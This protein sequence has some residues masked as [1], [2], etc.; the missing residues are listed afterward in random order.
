MENAAYKVLL[1]EDDKID[2]AAFKQLV[3]DESLP[4]DYTVTGSVSE[5]DRALSSDKFD[6]AIIDYLLGDGTAFDIFDRVKDIPV[7][8][9]TGCGDES[10]AVKAMKAGAYDYLIKDPE[11]N[12]LKVLPLTVENVVRYKKV[13]EQLGQYGRLK[14]ELAMTVSHELRVSLHIFKRIVSDAIAGKLG[15]AGNELQKKLQTADRTIDRLAKTIS[16]FLDISKIETGK[17]ELR[18]TK[19]DMHQVISEAISLLTDAAAEKGVKLL[20]SCPSD[21]AFTVYADHSLMRQIFVNLIDNAIR[22]SPMG[23]TIR[24]GVVDLDDEVQFSMQDTSIG[25]G[26]DDISRAF[27]YFVQS[28]EYAGPGSPGTGLGLYIAKQ[29]IAIQ[30]GR[31]WADSIPGQ[32]SIFCF[33]LPKYTEQINVNNSQPVEI[34]QKT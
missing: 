30:G 34:S 17:V 1:V 20:V 6:I 25:I 31:I 24:L 11:R 9:T 13:Q 8:I 16:D 26:S 3:E 15:P 14:S 22:F 21:P 19:T 28:D 4:Y 5:A 10:V 2:Q 27:N 18:R 33:T 12:Y 32:G 7:I 23:S 29:L